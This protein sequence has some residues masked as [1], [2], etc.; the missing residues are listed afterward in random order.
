M[1]SARDPYVNVMRGAIAAFSAG[2]GGADSVSVLPFTLALGLPD[3]LARRLA[4][5]S[6][7]ILLQESHLGFV[8]DPAAGAGVFEALTQGLC[9]KAWTLFQGLESEGGLPRALLA[10]PLSARGRRGGARTRARRGEPEGAD[11]RRQRPSRSQ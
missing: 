4:R 2:L 8:A 7:L 3:A 6:Q 9:E 1:L 10:R 11:D 5:N